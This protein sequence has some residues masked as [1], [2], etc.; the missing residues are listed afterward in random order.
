[1]VK[2]DKNFLNA[3]QNSSCRS[4]YAAVMLCLLVASL[5]TSCSPEAAQVAAVKDQG[6]SK[7]YVQDPLTL[8][9]RTNKKEI[10]IA[11]Q[12]ELVLETA[13]P[14]N[15][16][17]EFPSYALSLGDFTLKDTRIGPARMTGSGASVRIVHQ[18][19]YLLEP[20]LSGTYTIPA[21]EVTYHDRM[22]DAPVTKLVTEELQVPVLSLLGPDTANVEIKDIKPPLSLDPDRVL[23]FLVGAM[24]LL[25]AAVAA[26]R[27]CLLEKKGRRQ[28]VRPCPAA[29]RGYC[30]AG[31]GQ[32]AGRK[33]ARRR[34]SQTIPPAHL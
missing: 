32:A 14:E 19:T 13:V 9:L 34:G 25:L 16:E 1:M 3:R 31:A 22:K 28:A 27:L 33:P 15:V 30:F 20:Y 18:V 24:V 26:I 5:L 10:T 23:Q 12:L 4:I 6:I 8:H 7:N 21:L 2:M 17:V 29:A 11:E